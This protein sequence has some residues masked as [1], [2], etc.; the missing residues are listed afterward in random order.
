[1]GVKL[2]KMV[3][4]SESDLE[5]LPPDQLLALTK[6]WRQ[7]IDVYQGILFRIRR[8]LF[9]Q[10]S[11]RR[12]G[13]A[14]A[15]LAPPSPTPRS[16]TTKLPSQRYP[17]AVVQVEDVTFEAA[18]VCPAC[19]AMMQDSGM[20]EESEYLTVN[21]KEFRVTQQRR[22]KHRCVKCHGAIVTAP[23]G[24]RV[25]PGGSYGDELIID[26]TVSKYCDLI[27]MER[28]CQ[29]ARRS[30]FP[31]LPPHSLIQSTMKLSQFLMDVFKKIKAETLLSQVLR[32]DETPHR[33]LEGDARHRWYLW[34]FFCDTACFF[35]CHD[36]RSGDV[37]TAVL[38]ASKCEV[39]VSDVYSGYKKSIRLANE[40]R[41]NL[42]RPMIQAAFCNAHARREF[43]ASDRPDQEA[44]P[45]DAQFMLDQYQKI[46]RLEAEA[47]LL[48]G[49]AAIL[50]K[51]TAMAPIFESMRAEAEAKQGSYSSK[52]QMASAYS[53]FLKNYDGL[54]LFLSNGKTPID[55]NASERGLRSHVVGRKTWYGTHSKLGGRTAA[56]LFSIVESC[57][58]NAVNPREYFPKI[59]ADL[60]AGKDPYTPYEF[61]ART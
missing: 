59:C 10:R 1:M 16:E 23:A 53:Y 21:A 30:G 2:E 13:A 22:H 4:P 51:R 5:A 44:L 8:Q 11:E 58:L 47:K 57:R 27:P 26:A 56:I 33:M 31:G 25:I 9:G 38:N 28:Y 39:L 41:Q 40:L 32:A 12:E 36:T 19:G 34:G 24:L 42:G 18:P 49:E 45:S 54:T 14:T 6:Q 35:E 55:N 17:D 48:S 29:M 43:Y 20:S 50:A 37:S 3:L 61:K 46:Y 60:L 15:T 7:R 52:S